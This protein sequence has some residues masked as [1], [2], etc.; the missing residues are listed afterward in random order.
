MNT[1]LGNTKPYVFNK[2][3]RVYNLRLLGG[4][5]YLFAE[6][7]TKNSVGI[8]AFLAM[9]PAITI[10]KPTYVDVLV[11]DPNNASNYIQVSRK[12]EPEK[13]PNSQIVSNSSYFTG[14]NN[15]KL[16]LGLSFKAGAEFNWGNFST[17]FKSIEIGYIFDFLASNPVILYSEKNNRFFSGFY[18]SF[19]LGKNR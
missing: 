18:I 9:G 17:E 6:R 4:L 14:A 19:A 7:N 15:T 2:I 10:I 5:H 11:I 3:N 1:R 13:I 8:A 16:G 12:Y